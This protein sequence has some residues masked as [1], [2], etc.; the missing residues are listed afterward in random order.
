MLRAIVQMLWE[1]YPDA[2]LTM[3]PTSPQGSSPFRKLVDAG[4]YPKSSLYRYGIQWGDAAAALPRRLRERYGVVVEREVDVV[5]DAAG[6]TYSEQWGL[7]ATRELAHSMHRWKRRG[8]KVILM[9][10]AFGPFRERRI[11]KYIKQA[12]EHADLVMPRE[13]TS[14]T[15][16]TQVVGKQPQIRQYPDFTNLVEGRIPPVFNPEKHRVCLIPNYRMIDKA[17]RVESSAY[18]PFMKR[19]ARHLADREAGP[20]ILVHEGEKD[21]WLAEQLSESCG[22]LPILTLEDP[23][24]IKG[25]IGASY[26]AIGSR[27]HGLVS[28]LSQGVPSLGAG[29]S[30]KYL[31]LFRD[32]G[33]EDGLVAVT[34]SKE[35]ITSK[36]D[37]LIEGFGNELVSKTLLDRSNKLKQET[38]KMWQEVYQVFKAS[39]SKR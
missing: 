37:S 34:E 19:C 2:I 22:G 20:F 16:L 18:L 12:V 17:S 21:R 36:I 31:E 29:W 9:P 32:Y 1:A 7:A 38:E 4:F 28:A 15:Y 26:A 11:R 30:H 3:A 39:Q 25:V 23:L 13:S 33:V 14:N 24:E 27:Y 35:T 6:F 5:I 8:T 10:Q